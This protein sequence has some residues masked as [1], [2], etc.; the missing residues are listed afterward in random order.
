MG[1]GYEKDSTS[2]STDKAQVT[3]TTNDFSPKLSLSYEWTPNKNIYFTYASGYR[4]G[5]FNAFAPGNTSYLPETINSYELG[6]KGVVPEYHI[7][8]SL[9]SYTM[10]IS[11]MQVQQYLGAN[12]LA[13][14]NAGK[15]KST[16]V[17]GTVDW[18][19]NDNWSLNSTIGVNK[20]I[21]MKFNDGRSDYKGK[22][23]PFSPDLTYH[24]GIRYDSQNWFATASLDG[25]GRTYLEPANTHSRKAFTLLDL[26]YSYRIN[27]NFTTTLYSNNVLNTEYDYKGFMNGQVNAYSPPRELGVQLTY[28]F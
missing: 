12:T 24:V 5:G 28:L 9:S 19:I 18:W 27:R 2:L 17:E 1:A 22:L 16:G 26:A 10:K 25:M 21:F 23:T 3:Q 6:F 20:T 13:I 11:N 14:S 15:A 7:N 8:Y 4:Q